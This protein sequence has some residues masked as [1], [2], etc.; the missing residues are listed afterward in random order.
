MHPDR[1]RELWEFLPIGY[2]ATIAVELPF[3]LLGLS[4]R[5]G[6]LPCADYAAFSA[7]EWSG[8]SGVRT[9]TVLWAFNVLS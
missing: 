9:W 5:V 3:L 4:Q 6:S 8:N 2:F 7:Q 1:V